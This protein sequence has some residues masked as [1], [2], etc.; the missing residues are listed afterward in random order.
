MVNLSD[1]AILRQIIGLI[2]GIGRLSPEKPKMLAFFHLCGRIR[3]LLTK[4]L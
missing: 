4:K 1:R 3:R 2:G